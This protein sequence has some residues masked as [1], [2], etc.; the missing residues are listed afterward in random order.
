MFSDIIMEAINDIRSNMMDIDMD[1]LEDIYDKKEIIK[2]FEQMYYVVSLSDSLLPD[3][4]R[5]VSKR[6]MR[7]ICHEKAVK[8]CDEKWRD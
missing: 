6:E 8:W 4:S 5:T 3:G 2:M 1:I 7:E